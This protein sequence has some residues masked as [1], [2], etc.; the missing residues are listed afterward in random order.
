MAATY[1][2][3]TLPGH[4]TVTAP[5][6]PRSSMIGGVARDL[7][8][9]VSVLARLAVTHRGLLADALGAALVVAGV[10][11]WFGTGPGLI[12][13]GVAWLIL[14]DYGGGRARP[15]QATG[16]GRLRSIG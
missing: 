10:A 8:T 11:I 12:A 9:L 14:R 16:P 4:P 3:D 6:A 1:A 13:A 15:D 7:V 5:S 2:G